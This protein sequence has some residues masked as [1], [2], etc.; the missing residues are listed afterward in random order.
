MSKDAPLKIVGNIGGGVAL[1]RI[2]KGRKIM[3]DR[4]GDW[5][6]AEE[7]PVRS[8]TYPL[9]DHIPKLTIYPT[10]VIHRSL[11]ASNYHFD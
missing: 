5:S 11:S 3:R 1:P 10:L 8:A 7:I 4:K 2:E 6:N 9:Y